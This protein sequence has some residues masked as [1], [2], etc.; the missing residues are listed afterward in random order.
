MARSDTL[1]KHKAKIAVALLLTF[2]SGLVDIVGFLGVYR[3]FTAHVTGTTV[4][5]GQSIVQGKWTDVMAAC[6][7]VAAFFLGGVMGRAIIE[8]GA[9]R[10][11]RRIASVTLAMEAAMIAFVAAGNLPSA[12]AGA[13]LIHGAA[14]SYVY[15][16]IL[17]GA[18]GVQTATLTGVGPLTVHTTFVT[19]MVNKLAQLVTRIAFRAYDFLRGRRDTP[20]ERTQQSVESRQAIFIFSIWVFYVLGAAGGTASYM[21]WGFRALLVAIVGLMAGIAT[22]LVTPLSVEEEKEQAER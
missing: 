6:A 15:L 11:F 14:H 9:R 12:H 16:A 2:A 8:A 1:T 13:A 4:H 20:Q 7:V 21:K 18:M 5:L 10:R 19:G 17:A 22:D 3:L